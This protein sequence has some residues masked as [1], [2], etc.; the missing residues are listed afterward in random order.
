MAETFVR[1]LDTL[2]IAPN[3]PLLTT[4]T[5]FDSINAATFYWTFSDDNEDDTQSEYW[6]EIQRTS[7]S[8]EVYSTAWVVSSVESHEVPAL[9]LTNGVQYRWRVK[10]KD[11][12][13]EEGPFSDWSTFTTV[14]GPIVNILTPAALT[15]FD[16]D[17]ATV[18][19]EQ[20]SGQ[21][22]DSFRV[23][24]V[25]TA[26]ESQ[27][28]T[29]GWV[30]ST[31]TTYDVTEMPGD[32]R[33]LRIEVTLRSAGVE[34]NTDTV[35]VTFEFDTPDQA[36]ISLADIG[37]YV[38]LTIV[39]PTPTGDRPTVTENQVFRKGPDDSS[40]KRIA[41]G[42]GNNGVYKDYATRSR[43]GYSYFVRSIG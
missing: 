33:D 34:G 18:T 13:S 5:G 2:N 6:M 42:I 19:W 28:S 8:V 9:T 21:A 1:Y 38:E 36:S 43:R 12:Y 31:A 35:T 11:S 30:T 32:N 25:D 24:V 39:N 29:S 10:T 41:V 40:F 3:A 20:T 22:F 4:R 14:D 17:T 26:D 15:S 7:D 37:G 16:V 27:V 23:V